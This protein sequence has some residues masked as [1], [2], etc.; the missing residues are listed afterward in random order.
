MTRDDDDDDD[1]QQAVV[2]VCVSLFCDSRE[3]I[4]NDFCSSISVRWGILPGENGP[5]VALSLLS[6]LP[7]DIGRTLG[8]VVS[9]G[10]AQKEKNA[11]GWGLSRL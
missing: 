6:S 2:R 11:S 10:Q 4:A 3:A 8:L 7:E 1:D 5:A 9:R